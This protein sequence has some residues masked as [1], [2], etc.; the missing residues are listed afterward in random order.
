MTEDRCYRCGA[1]LFENAYK[2]KVCP[3]CGIIKQHTENSDTKP[4]YID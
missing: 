3:N 1:N 2:D 4:N